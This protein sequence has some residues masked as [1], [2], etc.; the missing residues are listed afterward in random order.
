MKPTESDLR[1]AVVDF[2]KDK[3]GVVKIRRALSAW[4]WDV[5]VSDIKPIVADYRRR[6]TYALTRAIDIHMD[7][8]TGIEAIEQAQ[9][10][11]GVKIAGPTLFR[12]LKKRR[13]ASRGIV[14]KVWPSDHP[15]P[16]VLGMGNGMADWM[17]RLKATGNGQVPRVA[18]AAWRIGSGEKVATGAAETRARSES[19]N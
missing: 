19:A 2:C 9:A 6:W 3:Y 10:E 4:G 5:T 16:G 11:T 7:G 18:A 12:H 14:P 1:A 17:D 13:A 15:E 8:A